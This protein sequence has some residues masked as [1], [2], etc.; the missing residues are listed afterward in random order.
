MAGAE[1]LIDRPVLGYKAAPV[2]HGQLVQMHMLQLTAM[3]KRG[4]FFH[5]IESTSEVVIDYG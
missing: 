4:V 1:S 2:R 5:A 3:Y